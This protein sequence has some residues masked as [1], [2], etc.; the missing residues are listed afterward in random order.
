[1][2]AATFAGKA[3]FGSTTLTAVGDHDVFVAK[4]SS[5][6][7][8]I[9]ATAV[10]GPGYDAVNNLAVDGSGNVTIAGAFV[11]TATFGS[12][13]LTAGGGNDGFI[14][15]LDGTG[16]VLWAAQAYS[17]ANTVSQLELAQ[18]LAVDDA[19]NTYVSGQFFGKATLGTFKLTA[20]VHTG[21]RDSYVAKLDPSG[22]FVWASSYSTG[23]S[24]LFDLVLD[25][26]GN[27]YLTGGLEGS[28]VDVVVAK[29]DASGKFVWVTT[30]PNGVTGAGAWGLQLALD[31]A[32][33]NIYVV[34]QAGGT[35]T[36][37]S[38]V[39][40]SIGD[41]DAFVAK[42]NTSG[43]F[44][45]AERAGGC[46]F[47]G[48]ASVKLCGTDLCIAGWFTGKASFTGNIV[49]SKGSADAVVWRI[50]AP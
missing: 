17:S 11:G 39:L 34:G 16:K 21:W 44:I 10:G 13:N 2:R 48:V 49:T 43:A 20:N 26:K 50:P 35:T 15:R 47:D 14:A 38:K 41:Q 5:T 29:V 23:I 37:G 9:W 45:A 30:A 32:S 31:Y 19:G 12:V 22:K 6:G 28:Y 18:G 1:M 7:Q 27:L 4:L 36:F 25:P 3:V 40:T 24:F 33:G 46:Q 42:L 8:V